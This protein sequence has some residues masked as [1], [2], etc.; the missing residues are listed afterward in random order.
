[1]PKTAKDDDLTC[2]LMRSEILQ[3]YPHVR[4][5]SLVAQPGSGARWLNGMLGDVSGFARSAI[6]YT[7]NHLKSPFNQILF[8][9]NHHQRRK[10]YTDPF[11]SKT[12]EAK[13]IRKGCGQ[14]DKSNIHCSADGVGFFAFFAK[15]FRQFLKTL[16]FNL[17]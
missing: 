11:M 5:V 12:D 7:S 16:I 3:Y 4:K 9:Q 6:E 14:T 10:L 15:M 1:M 17:R 2:E 13:T 8:S